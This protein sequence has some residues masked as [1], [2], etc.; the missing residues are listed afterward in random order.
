LSACCLLCS[1]IH[2]CI[3]IAR[4]DP[5]DFSI[6]DIRECRN[7]DIRDA[8]G[9][10]L[11]SVVAE[12]RDGLGVCEVHDVLHVSDVLD[13]LVFCSIMAVVFMMSSGVLAECDVR[14]RR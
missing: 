1:L 13:G 12:G 9:V 11:I 4:E 14:D 6:G 5:D 2:I 8:N 7:N 10:L 3:V